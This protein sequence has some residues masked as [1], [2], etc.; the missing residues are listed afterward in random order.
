MLAFLCFRRQRQ[1]SRLKLFFFT[2]LNKHESF[3]PATLCFIR[4][5]FCLVGLGKFFYRQLGFK[6]S[7]QKIITRE[8]NS[9][10]WCINLEGL[11]LALK[12]S[13][14]LYEIPKLKA[15][16]KIVGLTK[17]QTCFF[18]AKTSRFKCIW[19][20]GSLDIKR[21]HWAHLKTRDVHMISAY[22]H[23]YTRLSD[24]KKKLSCSSLRL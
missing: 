24:A 20:K 15:P 13:V 12:L 4:Q 5:R 3:L 10:N 2:F 19:L 23:E 17:A 9:K 14:G 11:V 7:R 18:E 1:L 6:L 8:S 21:A 22:A 16:L